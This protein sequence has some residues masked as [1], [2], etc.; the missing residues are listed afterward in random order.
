MTGVQT[1]A[2]PISKEIAANRIISY[3]RAMTNATGSNV[4][5][6]YRL[7]D[8]KVE[9]LEFRVRESSRCIGVPLKDMPIKDDVLVGAIIRG[10]TCIIPGGDDVIK[11]H[12][13]VIVVTTMNGLH[14][15]DKILKEKE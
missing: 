15:L 8:N 10:G 7:A 12:D 4:E 3:V 1:C 6:L 14:E 13:S 2:L 5:M 9:A 11:A